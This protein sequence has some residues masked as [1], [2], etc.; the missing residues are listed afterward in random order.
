MEDEKYLQPNEESKSSLPVLPVACSRNIE[1]DS[2]ATPNTSDSSAKLPTKSE[3]RKALIDT[4][5]PFE[6]VTQAV[7]KFS[8]VVDWT[9]SSASHRIQTQEVIEYKKKAEAAEEAKTKAINELDSAK[10]LIEELKLNLEK[11]QKEEQQAK[12]DSQLANL[13]TEELKKGIIGDDA[14][15]A[16]KT[17][18]EVAKSRL[19][20]ELSELKSVKEKLEALRKEHDSLVNEKE[21]AVKKAEEAVSASR[22][23]EMTVE[24]LNNQRIAT[25]RELESIHAS[26]M[27][28]EA[29]QIGVVM[30]IEQDAIDYEKEL[31]QAEE[32]LQRINQ[33]ILS[34]KDVN[35]KLHSASDLLA[36]LKSELEAYMES[37]SK[38]E[39]SEI[40]A[41]IAS[42]RKEVKEVRINIEKANSEVNCLKAAS[43]SLQ[44]ELEKEQKCV[45][46]IRQRERMTSTAIDH[47]VTNP[48]IPKQLQQDA[49]EAKLKAELAR[50]EFR[51]A[52][53]DAKRAKAGASTM[54]TRLLATQS[55]IEAAKASEMFALGA[56]RALRENESFPNDATDV[57]TVSVEEYYELSKEAQ[58]AEEQANQRVK[59][60]IAEIELAKDRES[61]TVKQLDEVNQELSATKEALSV[62]MDK[63]EK[64]KEGKLGAEQELI[65]WKNEYDDEQRGNGSSSSSSC[66]ETSSPHPP[67]P[68][69]DVMVTKK[70]KRSYFPRFLMFMS[71]RKSHSHSSK[72]C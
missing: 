69:A 34:A 56:L 45:S 16:A 52:E 19:A 10:R 42:A 70:K 53:E 26:H 1:H 14:S 44:L 15:I 12:Q 60:V 49:D 72:P 11:E 71:R 57:T 36:D 68:P 40:Q 6:S 24:N 66:Q 50:E 38:E 28:A 58:E 23:V 41:A 37:K 43:A 4:T 61:E 59:D 9:S 18:L 46:T 39:G 31:K 51:K 64:A 63:A 65:K 2:T 22:E 33:R 3:L 62:A 35:S 13:R 27:E 8:G 29:H 47:D 7:S 54:E 5:A 17:Q 21:E 32:E 67:L 25:K 20:T 48:E 30:A 55:G